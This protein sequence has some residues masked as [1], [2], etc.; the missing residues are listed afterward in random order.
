[1]NTTVIPE[2]SAAIEVIA[3]VEVIAPPTSSSPLVKVQILDPPTE[4]EEVEKKKK[5]ST[6]AKVM[7]RIIDIDFEQ[8][9]WDSLRSFFE[10]MNYIR[11]KA[12]KVQKD[13]QAEVNHHFEEKVEVE[14]LLEKKMAEVEDLQETVRDA[15]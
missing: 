5:K 11:S 4:K 13:H 3:T 9:I 7:D 12:V 14:H 10:V 1:M 8:H 2:T 6:I 15:K